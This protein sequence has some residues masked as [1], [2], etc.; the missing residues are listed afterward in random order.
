MCGSFLRVFM[1]SRTMGNC[2]ELTLLFLQVGPLC[3]AIGTMTI[4]V[5]L[6]RGRIS[7]SA[8]TIKCY[9]NLSVGVWGVVRNM[10]SSLIEDVR[11]HIV[12]NVLIT[13]FQNGRSESRTTRCVGMSLYLG[14]ISTINVE[15]LKTICGF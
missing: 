4:V 13:D 9:N 15:W 1:F 5:A 12:L 10:F 3:S 7:R 11:L 8:L 2:G 14:Y 6:Q